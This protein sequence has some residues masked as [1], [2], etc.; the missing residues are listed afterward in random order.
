MVAPSV[1]LWRVISR[2]LDKIISNMRQDVEQDADNQYTS[3]FDSKRIP[4]ITMNDYLN[5]I[6]YYT[7][8]SLSC[9][10]VALIYID[11]LLQKNPHLIL[12]AIN[13]H[14][15]TLSAI[16]LAIK[17]IDDLYMSNSV[18]AKI[19]GVSLAELNYMEAGM[20][21]L[22]NYEL[23]IDP[24]TYFEYLNELMLQYQKMQEEIERMED[25]SEQISKPIRTIGSMGS[26]YTVNSMQDLAE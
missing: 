26:I 3:V 12:T 6:N 4:S 16:I 21:L 24:R 23:Y 7:S 14:R 19:G 15:I 10:V 8:C 9:Y 17:Y 2:I 25:S 13:I 11:K 18:Y 22:L 20:L 1:E 5:R